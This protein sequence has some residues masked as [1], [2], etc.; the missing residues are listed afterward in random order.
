MG[1]VSNIKVEPSDVTWGAVDLGFIDGDIECSFEEQAVD[2]TAHQYG[3]NVLD[4][5]RTG[6]T[7]EITLNLK[8]SSSTTWE[9]LFGDEAG[10]ADYTPAA[11]T[12]VIGWGTSKDFTGMLTQADK[13]ILHPVTNASDNYANDIC[14]WKAYPMPGSLTRSGENPTV[15]SVTFKVFP[16]LTLTEEVQYFVYGDHTQTFTA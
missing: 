2:I 8:E 13:L 14:F 15:Y 10:G 12:E 11:G 9:N 3:T 4:G 5:I 7:M 1:T 6:K 16:D